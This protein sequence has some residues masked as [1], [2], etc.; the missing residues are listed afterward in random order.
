[1][2]APSAL[3]QHRLPAFYRR[4][5]PALCLTIPGLLL[6]LIVLMTGPGP[7]LFSPRLWLPLLVMALPAAY[8]WQE[9]VDVCPTGL[10]RRIQARRFIPYGE[11]AEWVYD[12]RPGVRVL[13]VFD[14]GR[15]IL[16]ECR[17]AHL[18]G[19]ERVL[20]ALQTHAP[21]AGRILTDPPEPSAA[22]PR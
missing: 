15:Q 5:L 9:G 12:A 18:T 21:A 6:L 17:A 22:P 16:L 8:W 7:A 1:M 19:F 11:V 14:T 3:S 2:D 13:R 20:D 4:A 10:R